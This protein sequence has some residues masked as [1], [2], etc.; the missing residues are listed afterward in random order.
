[1]TLTGDMPEARRGEGRPAILQP[2]SLRLKGCSAMGLHSNAKR[3]FCLK[4]SV[5]SDGNNL[6]ECV[7]CQRIPL[8]AY[9]L[10][11]YVCSVK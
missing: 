9:K 1:M 5:R 8:L 11:V 10:R 4:L 3:K 6:E 2:W 7:H